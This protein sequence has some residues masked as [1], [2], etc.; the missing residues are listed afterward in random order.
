MP[1][2][3][4]RTPYPRNIFSVPTRRSSDL[5]NS[6]LFER[7][8]AVYRTARAREPFFCAQEFPVEKRLV[9]ARRARK[10]TRLDSSHRCISYAVF[11]FKKKKLEQ[12]QATMSGVRTLVCLLL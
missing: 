7:Q 4:S 11:C 8:G 12:K 1:F 3:S 2:S 9:R 5:R 10:S 6:P